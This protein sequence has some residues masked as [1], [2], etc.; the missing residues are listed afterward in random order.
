MATEIRELS[1][2]CNF[3]DVA[4][5]TGVRPG[6]L[7]RSGELSR[8]D[9][10][11]RQALRHLGITD[12]AD[13]RSAREVRRRGPGRVPDGVDIHLLPIP[14]LPA[15]QS[16]A[17]GEP[18][19]EHAFR[20]LMADKPGEESV[21]EA[22]ARYMH[23][24]YR[25]F[26]AYSGTQRALHRLVTLLADGRPV[27]AH[28][29]AGKDRTGFLIAVVLETVGIDRDAIVTDFLRSNAAIP[30][31]RA[32][33]MEMIAQRVEDGL[34]PEVRSLTE[35]RLSEEVLG[36]REEYLATARRT[37]DES[38]GSLDG[39]LRSAAIT[40]AEVRRLRDALLA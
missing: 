11:G 4:I 38:Y 34:T 10:H 9:D 1:G 22:A 36:V 5:S 37:I 30:D 23:D 25:K 40:E 2:A 33:I 19:H 27:L 21:A 28:C 12:I 7:F 29:F 6:R 24:E 13:F 16:E 18:P 39:F 31:L 35:A 8:L 32:Q 20:R 15:E 26:P 14:D 3:R 17:D